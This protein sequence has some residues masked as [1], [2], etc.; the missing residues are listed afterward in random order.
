MNRSNPSFE[1]NKKR[2]K[3]KIWATFIYFEKI[4]PVEEL[5]V[6]DAAVVVKASPLGE[7]FF[8][9]QRDFFADMDSLDT[10]AKKVECVVC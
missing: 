7:K 1:A 6:V 5:S 8:A 2:T 3:S 4:P 9:E 10:Q